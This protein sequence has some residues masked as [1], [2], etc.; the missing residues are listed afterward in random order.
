[1]IRSR[2]Q[3]GSGAENI[4]AQIPIFVQYFF[5]FICSIGSFFDFAGA[6]L[7]PATVDTQPRREV[8]AENKKIYKIVFCQRKFRK[9]ALAKVK[10]EFKPANRIKALEPSVW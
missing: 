7:L 8:A 3:D 9:N 4:I 5:G 6:S 1:L 2:W 10:R